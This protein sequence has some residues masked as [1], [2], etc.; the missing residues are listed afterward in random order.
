[1][2]L[3]GHGEVCDSLPEDRCCNVYP[4]QEPVIQE[5]ARPGSINPRL[6]GGSRDKNTDNTRP[7]LQ[8]NVFNIFSSAKGAVSDLSAPENR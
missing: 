2:S 8:L 4:Q 1:M 3:L 7:L 5:T 6:K